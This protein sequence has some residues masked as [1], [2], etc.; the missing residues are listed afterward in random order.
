MTLASSYE[1]AKSSL[2]QETQAEVNAICL[3][4]VTTRAWVHSAAM[5]RGIRSWKD[6][7]IF[8]QRNGEG[9]I[10]WKEEIIH[11]KKKPTKYMREMSTNFEKKFNAILGMPYTMQYNPYKFD[12]F[13]FVSINCSGVWAISD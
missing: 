3:Y 1:L 2:E 12:L 8:L 9:I 7:R 11:R 13:C 5:D 10:Q 6:E 4:T